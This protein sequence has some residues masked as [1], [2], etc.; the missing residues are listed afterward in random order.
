M[1]NFVLLFIV[2]WGLCLNKR[3]LTLKSTPLY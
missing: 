1:T 3:N 2:V